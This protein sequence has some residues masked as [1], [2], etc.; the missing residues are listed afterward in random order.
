MT[1]ST[2]ILL[3][4]KL[5]DKLLVGWFWVFAPIIFNMLA[6]IIFLIFIGL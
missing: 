2:L 6:S 4:L 5:N 3:Y 1:I